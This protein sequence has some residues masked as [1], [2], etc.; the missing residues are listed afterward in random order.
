MTEIEIQVGRPLVLPAGWRIT[1]PDAPAMARSG[2]ADRI[3]RVTVKDRA[4][5]AV[6]EAL[7]NLRTALGKVEVLHNGGTRQP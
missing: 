4:D 5:P 1:P 7:A 6:R 2:F 3:L